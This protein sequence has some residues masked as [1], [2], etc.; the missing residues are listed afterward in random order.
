[1]WIKVLKFLSEI[2]IILYVGIC[3]FK[4]KIKRNFYGIYMYKMLIKI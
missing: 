4:L 3:I 2:I 1:M